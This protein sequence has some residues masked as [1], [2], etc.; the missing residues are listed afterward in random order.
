MVGDNDKI[1]GKVTDTV[2]S[3]QAADISQF[4]EHGWYDWVIFLDVITGKPNY[5]EFYDFC[6]RPTI[7]VGMETCTKI[8]V[9]NYYITVK[10]L[11][12][13]TLSCKSWQIARDDEIPNHLPITH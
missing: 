3:C 9:Y 1:Q 2:Q 10:T 12:L 6:L 5:K 11:N 13:S 7:Y 8:F 4:A